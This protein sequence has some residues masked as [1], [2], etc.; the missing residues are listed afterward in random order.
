MPN[1]D[2]VDPIDARILLELARDPRAT[3]VAV[4]ER[5]GIARNT[6]QARITRL[7][8]DGTLDTFERR[9]SPDAL[10]YS[11]TAFITA[12]VTQ[13]RL[14]EVGSALAAVPEVLEVHGISGSDDLLIHVVAAHADDLYRIAGL[15]LAIPGIERSST[16]LVMRRLVGYRVTPLLR[17]AAEG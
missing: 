10:G 2:G 11:L 12:R 1:Q 4:A 15:I 13:R 8:R 9:V 3:T 17:R 14:D 7:E 16:A 6:A 5:V